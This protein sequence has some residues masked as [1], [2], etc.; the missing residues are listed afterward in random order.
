MNKYEEHAIDFIKK[1]GYDINAFIKQEKGPVD[2][3]KAAFD[4]VT[5]VR[6]ETSSIVCAPGTPLV[7]NHDPNRRIGSVVSYDD[8]KVT[9]ISLKI[10]DF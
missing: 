4:K 1:G 6:I 8:G 2:L 7:M 3:I 10:A 5:T 9:I